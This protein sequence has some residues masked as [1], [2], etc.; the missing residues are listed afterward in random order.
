[1]AKKKKGRSVAKAKRVVRQLWSSKDVKL[2]RKL[3]T[4]QPAQKIADSLG[5][6]VLALRYK[7]HMLGISLRPKYRAVR[8]GRDA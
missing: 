2:L 7:A 6:S 8:K 5:R 3:A 4:R 1:M